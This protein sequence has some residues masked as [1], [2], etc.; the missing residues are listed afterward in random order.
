MKPATGHVHAEDRW[1]RALKAL[2]VVK[3]FK[4]H[5]N[6]Y[7]THYYVVESVSR[8]EEWNPVFWLATRAG[9]VG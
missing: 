2:L 7:N 6:A 8:Q 4:L 5:L 3:S 1:P 9:K